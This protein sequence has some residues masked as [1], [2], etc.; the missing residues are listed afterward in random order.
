MH[1]VANESWE[2]GNGAAYRRL[3]RWTLAAVLVG[4][5]VGNLW[6]PGVGAAL[7]VTG[8]V[9]AAEAL[10]IVA[11]TKRQLLLVMMLLAVATVL[12]QGGPWVAFCAG[13][14]T[15]DVREIGTILLL[16]WLPHLGFLDAPAAM[17]IAG[18]FAVVSLGSV[19]TFRYE[20]LWPLAGVLLFTL[21]P[22]PIVWMFFS[23]MAN[24]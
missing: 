11:R 14:D 4:L 9:F 13:W 3:L 23:A 18:W 24:A 1:A 8:F 6:P 2:G 20:S 10:T 5:L 15:L 21:L 19:L 7:V 17:S 12:V 16:P 22:M